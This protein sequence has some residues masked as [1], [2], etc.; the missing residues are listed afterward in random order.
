MCITVVYT[1]VC[2]TVVYTRVEE[3]R[4]TRVL[5]KR[6]IPGCCSRFTV[7]LYPGVVPVSLLVEKED[8]LCNPALC[9]GIMRLF[10]SL[11]RFTVGHTLSSFPFPCWA[12]LHHPFHCWSILPAQALWSLIFSTFLIFRDV[13]N[14]PLGYS[15][16]VRTGHPGRCEETSRINPDQRRN[17][18]E[19]DKNTATESTL[20]QGSSESEEL[21]F[22]D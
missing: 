19:R 4:F 22:S 15:R 11:S 16:N 20:A 18:C 8:S 7:G 17:R 13:R 3:E 21:S 14:L 12:V 10:A 5:R 1:R 6:G 9:S 2:I